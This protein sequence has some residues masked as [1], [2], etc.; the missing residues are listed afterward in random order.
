MNEL[1]TTSKSPTIGGLIGAK[2]YVGNSSESSCGGQM[3]QH[4][5]RTVEWQ[6]DYGIASVEVLKVNLHELLHY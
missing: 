3:L 6:N 5:P 1:Y 4:A 2:C